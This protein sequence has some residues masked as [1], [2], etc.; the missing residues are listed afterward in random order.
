MI[1]QHTPAVPGR[2]AGDFWI[3]W[4]GQTISLTDSA[5]TNG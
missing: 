1:A 5:L 2:R 4:T 3:Y